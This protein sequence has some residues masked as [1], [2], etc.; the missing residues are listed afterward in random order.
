MMVDHVTNIIIAAL[1]FAGALAGA[2]FSNRKAQALMEYRLEE[3]AALL[4]K[5]I[6]VANHR[7]DDLEGRQ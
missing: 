7:I 1:G 3:Q 5:D 6:K 4:Q 2:Y